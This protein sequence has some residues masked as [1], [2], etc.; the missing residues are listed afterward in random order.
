LDEIL[1]AQPSERIGLQ[2]FI[3]QLERARYL[4]VGDYAPLTPSIGII[5]RFCGL[6]K[7]DQVGKIPTEKPAQLRS[8]LGGR[9]YI[10][11]VV[12]LMTCNHCGHVE[13]FDFHRASSWWQ[14]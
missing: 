10:K 1:K 13:L 7:Y 6:G 14:K 3:D 8:G 2:Q 4:I 11:A 12:N 9:Q 5:C